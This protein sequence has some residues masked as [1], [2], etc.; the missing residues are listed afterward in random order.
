MTARGKMTMRAVLERDIQ[1]APD[2][3]GALGPPDWA[4]QVAELPGYLYERK[5]PIRHIDGNKTATVSDLIY[6]APKGTD[7]KAGDR[8]NGVVD[9][10]GRVQ[11]AT[12]LK[13]RGV[14]RRAAWGHLELTLIDSST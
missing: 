7:V 14:Q 5:R 10:L 9:R 13:V 12:P 4:V 3:S 1:A 8:L 11:H 2:D 6:M